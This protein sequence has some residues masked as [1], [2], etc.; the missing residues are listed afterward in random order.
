ML[1]AIAKLL[2]RAVGSGAL[3]RI[4]DAVDRKVDSETE[5]QRIKAET[6]QAYVTAQAKTLAGRGW[7]FPLFFIVPLGFWWSSVL[8]YSVLL[9][10][11]CA[12]PQEW[13]IAELPAP[14]DEWAGYIIGSL[15]IGRI[16]QQII[17]RWR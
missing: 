9:C 14:L 13:S 15:F 16:G 11:K 8:V 7:W 17:E 12:F 1:A 3:D 10:R 6:V 2:G 4:L 5:R